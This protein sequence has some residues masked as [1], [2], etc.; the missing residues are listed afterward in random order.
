[1]FEY[2][3]SYR[4]KRNLL[5]AALLIGAAV[6]LFAGARMRRAEALQKSIAGEVIR[7][8][9]LANS[10]SSQD[11][12]LKL[13]VRDV[14][15]SYMNELLSDSSGIEETRELLTSHLDEMESLAATCI[16]EQGY[17]Y[18]VRAALVTDDF[19]QKTYGDC[20]FPA[21]EYEALRI[22][23]GNARGHNWWCMVYPGLC[24][25][26]ESGAYVSEESKEL[27]KHVL[28]EEEFDLVTEGGK[29][30]FKFRLWEY[31]K[32]KM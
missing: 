11:Q 16:R 30:Q 13:K 23:I 25:T 18:P 6:M 26:E 3:L 8:H 1:M 10:D 21:G 15:L 31:L 9:V 17:T 20:T 19:P 27:L 12:A 5:L 14:L 22:S 7:F 28:T 29:I 32:G 24:F 4:R 2:Y